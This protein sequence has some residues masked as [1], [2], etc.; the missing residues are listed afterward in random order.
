MDRVY[1]VDQMDDLE[2]N[3]I[4]VIYDDG[5]RQLM[6]AFASYAAATDRHS[7]DPKVPVFIE[8]VAAKTKQVWSAF[9][10]AGIPRMK[11][12]KIYVTENTSEYATVEGNI[13][14]GIKPLLSSFPEE[15]LVVSITHELF[16]A[17]Q[18]LTNTRQL[19]LL[20]IC[21]IHPIGSVRISC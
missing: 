7:T 10:K 16:H 19:P 13:K 20:I 21:S 6:E 2:D 14:L 15:R 11:Q 5:N 8:D 9:D 18:E 3:E 4:E 17:A 12:L 1:K